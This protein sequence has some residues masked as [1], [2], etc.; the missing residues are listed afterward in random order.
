[1][2]SWE[3]YNGHTSLGEFKK[4]TSDCEQKSMTIRCNIHIQKMARVEIMGG[5][6][7]D[8]WHEMKYTVILFINYG[9]T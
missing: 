6:N 9:A 1:M 8:T 3:Y 2:Y 5:L 4:C 7:N